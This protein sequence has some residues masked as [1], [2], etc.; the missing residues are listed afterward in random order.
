[1]EKELMEFLLEKIVD[2]EIEN[3]ELKS[4]NKQLK[5]INESANE[6]IRD[7]KNYGNKN[8]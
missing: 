1:M 6:I 8:K 2:L 5:N 7:L 3:R 4:R